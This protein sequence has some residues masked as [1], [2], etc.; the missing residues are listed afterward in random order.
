MNIIGG[1]SNEIVLLGTRANFWNEKIYYKIWAWFCQAQSKEKTLGKMEKCGFTEKVIIDGVFTF[2]FID[3][4]KFPL[5]VLQFVEL[6]FGYIPENLNFEKVDFG[7]DL[8]SQVVLVGPNGARKNTLLN[9]T[10][11]DLVPLGGMVCQHNHLH[12]V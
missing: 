8:D 7:V 12:V 4:G 1:K 6:T 10:I 9:L 3:V 11:K 5:Y 2:K